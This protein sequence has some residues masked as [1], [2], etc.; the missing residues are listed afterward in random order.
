MFAIGLF[1]LSCF[2]A[3]VSTTEKGQIRFT[4]Q[5]KAQSCLRFLWTKNPDLELS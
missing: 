3:Y 5:R 4:F 2:K 1:W